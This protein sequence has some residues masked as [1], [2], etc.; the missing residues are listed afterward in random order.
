LQRLQESRTPIVIIQLE[1]S[2]VPPIQMQSQPLNIPVPRQAVHFIFPIVPKVEPH[3][4][5][6][7][8]FEPAQRG[9]VTRTVLRMTVK[10][11]GRSLAHLYPGAGFQFSFFELAITLG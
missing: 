11:P 4:S 7:S 9:Q 1:Q 6:R 8:N 3:L 10:S 2:C 5:H